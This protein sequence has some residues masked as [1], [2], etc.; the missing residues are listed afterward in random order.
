MEDGYV[1]RRE[2]EGKREERGEGLTAK[3]VTFATIR[4]LFFLYTFFFEFSST[5]LRPHFY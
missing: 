5:S 2:D 3:P 4:P 1:L